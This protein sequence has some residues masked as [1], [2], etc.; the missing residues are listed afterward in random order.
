M[1]VIFTYFCIGQRRYGYG[2]KATE[3][4]KPR[5]TGLGNHTSH[6]DTPCTTTWVSETT[7]VG[8]PVAVDESSRWREDWHSASSLPRFCPNNLEHLTTLSVRKCKSLTCFRRHLKT[9]LR[10]VCFQ[11]PRRL[12]RKCAQILNWFGSIGYTPFTYVIT[13]V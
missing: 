1:N 13:Y 3:C 6:T 8:E 5:I 10:S 7:L 2:G 12:S 9:H 4:L 11:H